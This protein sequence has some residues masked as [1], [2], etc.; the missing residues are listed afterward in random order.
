MCFESPFNLIGKLTIAFLTGQSWRVLK[1]WYA[2]GDLEQGFR[3]CFADGLNQSLVSSAAQAIASYARM[4]FHVLLD[5][6]TSTSL[7][8]FE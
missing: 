5:S 3:R 2:D 7:N 6:Q 4:L 1:S 8:L